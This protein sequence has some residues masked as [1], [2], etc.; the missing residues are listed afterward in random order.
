MAIMTPNTITSCI[1]S[2]F[3]MLSPA[4]VHAS[5]QLGNYPTLQYAKFDTQGRTLANTTNS[6][7]NS[8][9]QGDAIPLKFDK[10]MLANRAWILPSKYYG[11]Q[12]WVD[13]ILTRDWVRNMQNLIT[14]FVCAEYRFRHRQ[15]QSED[16]FKQESSNINA[17][18]EGMPFVSGQFKQN[19]LET[20]LDSTHARLSYK[21][22]LP[23]GNSVSLQSVFG[24]VH[25]LGSFFG[26]YRR[27]DNSLVL[28]IYSQVYRLN[29]DN[30]RGALINT[31]PSHYFVIL[32]SSRELAAAPN[33]QAAAKQALAQAKLFILNR[34][35]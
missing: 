8:I 3:F 26:P 31:T 21:M 34:A 10:E 12:Y 16:C 13:K 5:Y 27:N 23:S 30:F 4:L 33:Q 7:S 18:R 20:N 11:D 22:W 32:P 35:Y 29:Q 6:I 19:S 28:T 15:Y 2:L 25:E 24:S 14:N 17:Q 9:E 1:I